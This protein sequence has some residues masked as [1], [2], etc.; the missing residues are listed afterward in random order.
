MRTH[1]SATVLPNVHAPWL[2][3]INVIAPGHA[4]VN[5]CESLYLVPGLQDVFLSNDGYALRD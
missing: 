5:H 2:R 3:I 4:G 1:A